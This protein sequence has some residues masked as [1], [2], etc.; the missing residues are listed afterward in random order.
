MQ[1][2]AISLNAGQ[3]ATSLTMCMAMPMRRELCGVLPILSAT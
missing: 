3:K 2:S 1:D